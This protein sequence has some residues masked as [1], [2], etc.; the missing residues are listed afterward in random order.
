MEIVDVSRFD[1]DRVIRAYRD[2][3]DD[4]I[5]QALDRTVTGEEL[6]RCRR[7]IRPWDNFAQAL[8]AL[9]TTAR[10]SDAA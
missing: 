3:L 6:I 2:F 10:R 8:A 5:S 9:E 4:R 7:R 1:P